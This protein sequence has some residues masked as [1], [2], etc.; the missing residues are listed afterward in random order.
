M[1][2]KPSLAQMLSPNKEHQQSWQKQAWPLACAISTVFA[3][4][5]PESGLGL[6]PCFDAARCVTIGQSS[7]S[8]ASPV[9]CGR[10]ISLAV[11]FG[12]LLCAQ[13]L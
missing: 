3:C 11:C 8:V 5:L 4:P 2:P 12:P 7:K 13:N 6:D 9:I 1:S 10:D